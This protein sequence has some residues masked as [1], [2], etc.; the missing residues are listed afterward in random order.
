MPHTIFAVRRRCGRLF[1][2]TRAATLLAAAT[3]MS[4][5]ACGGASA[6]TPSNSIA[7]VYSLEKVSRRISF[8]RDNGADVGTGRVERGTVVVS[9]DVV[10]KG[11]LKPYTFVQ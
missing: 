10:G 8:R 1:R 9:L 6:T 4:A 5:T 11:T 2:I 3:M 7:G